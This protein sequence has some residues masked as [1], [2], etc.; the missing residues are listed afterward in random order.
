MVIRLRG[1][2]T[3]AVA[4]LLLGAAP[5]APAYLRLPAAQLLELPPQDW[6]GDQQPH[7]F[8]VLEMNRDG[9]RYWA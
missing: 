1:L 6:E 9:F 8:S 3:M 5:V 7:T 2:L 4:A